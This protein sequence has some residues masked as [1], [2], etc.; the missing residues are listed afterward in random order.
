MEVLAVSTEQVQFR[1]S[2]LVHREGDSSVPRPTRDRKGPGL[3]GQ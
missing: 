2:G 3:R 1:V